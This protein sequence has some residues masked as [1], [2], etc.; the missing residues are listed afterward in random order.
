VRAVTEGKHNIV[1]NT[2][3]NLTHSR[4]VTITLKSLFN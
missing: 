4:R 2:D 3:N 1:V